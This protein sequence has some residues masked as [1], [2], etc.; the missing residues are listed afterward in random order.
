MTDI[1]LVPP[2]LAAWA[3]CAAVLLGT[4]EITDPTRRYTA[5]LAVVIATVVAATIALFVLR[6]RPTAF[7]AIAAAAVAVV[8]AGAQVIAWNAPALSEV[9]R[10]QVQ[11][12][13]HVDGPLRTALAVAYLPIRTT[14][15][16]TDQALLI[17][18]PV[19]LALPQ[20]RLAPYELDNPW[21]VGTQIVVTGRIRPA[22]GSIRTAGYL[23]VSD[24]QDITIVQEPGLIDRVAERMRRALQGSLPAHPEGGSALVAG[25]ATGDEEAMS[26]EQMDHMRASG[27]AHLTAVSGGNVAIVV[28]AVLGLAW[29]LRVPVL[30]RIALALGSLG[31]YV[32]LVHP[33]PSVLR[34]GVMGAVVVAS[35]V[36]GGRRPG[37]SVLA[38]AVLVLVIA[39][40]PLALS[41]GFALSVAATGG[42]VMLAPMIRARIEATAW[43]ARLP[44]A[45]TIAASLTLSAQLATAPVLVAMGV[46]VGIAAV[47]ANLLAMPVV[48]IVTITGLLAAILG[49]IPG[50]MPLAN[51]VAF[52]GAWVAEWIAQIAR[53]AGG[54]DILRFRGSPIAALIAVLAVVVAVVAWRRGRRAPVA[55]VSAALAFAAALWVVFPPERRAWPPADWLMV[56]CDVGQGDGFVIADS[57]DKRSAVVI[58]TGPTARDIDRCL[59]DLDI[60]RVSALVL[61][62]FHADHVSGLEGVLSGRDVAA[63]F[64]SPLD[65]PSSQVFG[66]QQALRERG[67]E[68]RRLTAGAH[69]KIGDGNYRVL[70]PRRIIATSGTSS[71]SLANNASLVIDARVHGLR[72]LLTG[73][74]EPPVQA[75]LLG[76]VGGFDIA[77]VPHHGSGHQHPDFAAWA[78]AD[79]ALVS[80]GADNSFS[81]PAPST[82]Q[83]WQ[84][85]GALIART[86]WH[87]DIA[88]V[89][90]PLAGDR[91]AGNRWAIVP[92]RGS[93]E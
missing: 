76:E 54:I 27:L 78:D 31:F 61:T 17:D 84:H 60:T 66:V 20:D 56:Q 9:M 12:H 67:L 92:R 44:A 79:A 33:Q 18:V 39:A 75:A 47:P 4:A 19:T 74:I 35:L 22:G 36:I 59:S 62:H 45:V 32:V 65:E 11:V 68:L 38:T 1:R 46:S 30:A 40:P 82:L 8:S 34:A 41:W 23:D 85:T 77:K 58:D 70:W 37:P 42:I 13:A 87:R 93:V 71:G 49:A 29:W 63:V 69:L 80:V 57:P 25:L 89:H 73:D 72:L 6:N 21:P 10:H 83:A 64:A 50:L 51:V 14:V 26:P 7:V 16:E 81:H 5:A 53:I 2:A 15:I 88:V 3:M 55:I 24:P 90:Q 48:P 86:D 91:T 28:G 52:A 43:G